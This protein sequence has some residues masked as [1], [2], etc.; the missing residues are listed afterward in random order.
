MATPQR[1]VPQTPLDAF[2]ALLAG[3]LEGDSQFPARLNQA[4]Q[5][6]KKQTLRELGSRLTQTTSPKGLKRAIFGLV[7]RY[8]WPD[9]TPW[10]LQSLLQESD[11]GVFDE[12]CAALGALATRDAYEAL[13][14]LQS[15]RTDPNRQVIL[16]RELAQYT[17]QQHASYYLS[18]LQE[19]QGNPRLALQ[20]ARMLAASARAEDVPGLIEAYQSGDAATQKLALRLLASLPAPEASGFLMDLLE[21]G[22]EEFLD[23]QQVLLLLRSL[24][25]VPRTV[26]RAMLSDRLAELFKG[27][28]DSHVRAIQLA[29]AADEAQLGPA[30]DSLKSLEKGWHEHFVLE[31]SALLALG[32]VARYSAFESETI[33]D[34]ESRLEQLTV[35][36][37]QCAELLALQVDL[38]RLPLAEALPH[39]HALF[40][41]RAGG[42]GASFAFLRLVPADA[43]E[44]LDEVLGDPDIDRRMRYLDALGNREDD[45]LTPF[46]L[47]A[48][49]DS[50]IE[51]GQNALHHLGKLPSN[52][53]LLMGMFH[54]GQPD[55]IRRAIRAFGENLSKAAA[56][57]LM[58]FIQK[59]SGDSLVLEAV[60][61]LAYIVHPP[62]AST[63]L[64]LLHDGKPLNL[65]ISLTQALGLLRTPEA[66]LGLLA[67]S[68]V[69]KAAPVLILA[70]EGALN[71]FPGFSQ[72]L[73]PE[74]LEALL[75][76]LDRCCDEREGEGN[77]LR[78]MLAMENLFVFSQVTYERLRDRFSDFL[79]EMRTKEVWDKDNNERVAALIKELN[80]R[81]ESLKMLAER[82]RGLMIRLQQVPAKGPQRLEALLGLREALGD[83]ELI[84][85]PQIGAQISAWVLKEL[86]NPGNEWKDVAHL[87]EIGGLSRNPDLVE[88]I[89]PIFQRATGLG[90]KSAARK[91][92]LDLGLTEDD[93]NRR[94]P[95]RSILLLEP[96]AFFRKRLIQSLGAWTVRECGS[97]Q[98]AATLLEAEAVDLLISE[99]SD[100]DGDL[101]PW[102]EEQWNHKRIHYLLLSTA[103]RDPGSLAEAPWSLGALFKPYPLEQLLKT[104]GS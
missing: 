55:Q 98:E 75:Q 61:A 76:L 101:S 19:G 29:E 22:R 44:I 47:K 24:R 60:E 9:W 100:A 65:Q 42:E 7:Q 79:S 78:A 87:C 30:I 18:R 84:L 32:K 73:P 92:L 21:Q 33:E 38:G 43:T 31:A 54:S 41:V 8:D 63:Y 12:G 80:R 77:R 50:I 3:Y 14:K 40:Q 26:A 13:L 58:D 82:E 56:N 49:Q 93:L 83:A 90:L 27:R 11:L 99:C 34:T 36:L 15:A 67:K 5:K 69:L 62:A 39:L 51:V 70:L 91:A 97:R 81:A 23:I 45:A 89:R 96:S 48:A 74:H 17:P 53:P 66:S 72:P 2:R 71:A 57:D 4:V 95:I 28:G 85:R 37:D 52:L 6:L 94:A 104:L 25:G 88:V 59:D 86:E 46:F 103:N 16:N 20:G 64:D 68:T 1:T 10:F 35:L 102:I